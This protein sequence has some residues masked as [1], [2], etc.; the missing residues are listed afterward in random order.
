VTSQGQGAN[1]ML[2][3]ASS[4]IIQYLRRQAGKP[5]ELDQSFVR[6]VRYPT[7]A[8]EPRP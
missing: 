2:A 3:I 8:A 5:K 4:I 6:A 7:E 1:D